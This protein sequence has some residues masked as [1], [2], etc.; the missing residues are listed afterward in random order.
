MEGAAQAAARPASVRAAE[1]S[2]RGA[3]FP[4]GLAVSADL[5]ARDVE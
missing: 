2:I 1:S 3:R 4:A 5:A